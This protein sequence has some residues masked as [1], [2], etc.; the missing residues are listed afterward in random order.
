M[1]FPQQVLGV[2]EET[3]FKTDTSVRI[4]E[5]AYVPMKSTH[6]NLEKVLKPQQGDQEY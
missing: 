2:D 4:N 6:F 3:G 5:E 1:L